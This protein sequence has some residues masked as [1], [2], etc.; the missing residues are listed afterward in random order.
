M[1]FVSLLLPYPFYS[2]VNMASLEARGLKVKSRIID[3]VN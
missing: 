2:T 3:G 1:D